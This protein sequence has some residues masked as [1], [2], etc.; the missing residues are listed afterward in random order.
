MALTCPK[1][2]KPIIRKASKTFCFDIFPLLKFHTSFK[3]NL[4]LK[5]NVPMRKRIFG[6]LPPSASDYLSQIGI[7]SFCWSKYSFFSV[8]CTFVQTYTYI[9]AYECKGIMEIYARMFG[10]KTIN[11]FQFS[12]AENFSILFFTLLYCFRSSLYTHKI[13]AEMKRCCLYN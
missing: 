5:Q 2:N 8:S 6:I 13:C 3:K 9:Q 7:E 4:F 11:W 10:V 12:W 1:G